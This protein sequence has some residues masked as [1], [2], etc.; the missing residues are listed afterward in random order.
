MF[1]GALYSSVGISWSYELGRYKGLFFPPVKMPA[2]PS[3]VHLVAKLQ[4][5][6]SRLSANLIKNKGNFTFTYRH[7]CV[8]IVYLVLA[9]LISGLED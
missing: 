8:A 1:P 5:T 7:V 9:E 4:H 2:R 3:S 6:A